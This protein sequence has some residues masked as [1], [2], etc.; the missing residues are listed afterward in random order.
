MSRK[1]DS[2]Y[3]HRFLERSLVPKEEQP[4]EIPDTWKWVKL[5]PGAAECLDRFRKPV[6]ADERSKR[7]GDVPYYGATGQVG[8]IDDYLTNEELVLLGEDGAPFFDQM[9]PTAYLI[10]GKAWVNNHAHI[11]RSH[12][13][14]VG[15]KYLMYYLNRFNFHGYVSG[16]TRLKLT[17]KS[18][19][20]IPIPLP[21]PD[22]QK[23]IVERIESLLG[24]IE[25]AADLIDGVPAQIKVLEGKLLVDACLGNLTETWRLD[26][27][28]HKVDLTS[29]F[30]DEKYEAPSWGNAIPHTWGLIPLSKLIEAG[31]QNGLYKPQSAYGEG[32][33]IVRIDNFYDGTI[34]DWETLK[35]LSVTEHEISLYGLNNH[36]VLINRVNSIQFLGKSA[37][38]RNLRAPCVFESNMMR[39][40]LKRE[41][42]NPEYVV[43]FL[44]SILGIGELRK[45]AKHA[46]NQSSIN[47][48]DVKAVVV[49]LPPLQE[50]DEI[51]HIV[52]CQLTK[53][54]RVAD[55]CSLVSTSLTG[56]SRGV[57]SKTF[58][59]EL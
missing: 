19:G 20:N 53:V 31:P 51:V 30:E 21:P 45:N 26:N 22:E 46:V 54:Q 38:V 41:Y 4:H 52:Q 47:Q 57:M 11:L 14:S 27:G 28:M 13:G 58:R 24:K 25:E 33:M 18:M 8:L 29:L 5:L 59:G 36:D 9:K 6:N 48:T 39:L 56:T 49:P 50:Q 40:R 37:L 17:Q 43:L 32:T 7:I 3:V 34:N 35:K 44:K 55:Y 10:S 15:N 12:F 1:H 16:T 42:V 23:R 2:T